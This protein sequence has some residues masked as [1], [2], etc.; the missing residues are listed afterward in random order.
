MSL[1]TPN[2]VGLE[3]G[4]GTERAVAVLDPFIYQD[5]RWCANCGRMV[6]GSVRV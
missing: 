6:R 4:E 3:G 1:P 2:P 5:T